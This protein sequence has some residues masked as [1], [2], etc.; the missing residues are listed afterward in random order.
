LDTAERLFAEKGYAAT[1]L[2]QIISEA[3]VNLAAIHYY[4]RTKEDLL[5][6]VVVRRAAPVNE[7]R[8]ALLARCE[9]T[10]PRSGPDVEAILEAWLAP[11]FRMASECSQG[12]TPFARLMGRLHAEGD[13]LPRLIKSKFGPVLEVFLAALRRTLPEVPEQ[14]LACRM[15][16]AVGAMAHTLRGVQ[17]LECFSGTTGGLPDWDALLHYLV[18]F[19]A[20][21]F[22]GPAGSVADREPFRVE[23][24]RRHT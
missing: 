15:H 20:A 24:S 21:G 13:V 4:F 17:E 16:F 5:D 18:N 10:A 3:G 1:S 2:R 12:G 19:L 14:E 6:A 11:A 7:E 22:R 23:A 8:L 9:Q